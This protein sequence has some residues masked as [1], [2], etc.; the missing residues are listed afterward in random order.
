MTSGAARGPVLARYTRDGKLDPYFGTGGCSPCTWVITAASTALR[1]TRITRSSSAA[2]T[3]ESHQARNVR[4]RRA[5]VDV[6]LD[7]SEGSKASYTS[8][9]VES[10]GL[11]VLELEGIFVGVPPAVTRSSSLRKNALPTTPS[12]RSER[13]GRASMWQR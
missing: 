6:R 12:L 2:E 13:A 3:R 7:T 5:H 4:Y 8:S 10:G 11:V 9:S 1:S